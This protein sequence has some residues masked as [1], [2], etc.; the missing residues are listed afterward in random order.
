MV[1]MLAP[2]APH[3]AEEL[4][5]RLGHPHSLAYEPYPEADPQLVAE[6]VAT[7]VVQVAGRLRDKLEVPVD[8]GEEELRTRALAS[9]RVQRALAGRPV[10][11]VV[12]RGHR[13]VNVVPA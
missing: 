11:R 12:V 7:C 8:I 4:W 6:R 13:L 3:L 2:F 9:S 10:A 5:R 1:L